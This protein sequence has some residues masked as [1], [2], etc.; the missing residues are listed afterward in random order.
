MALEP[1]PGPGSEGEYVKAGVGYHIS[2]NPEDSGESFSAGKGAARNSIEFMKRRYKLTKVDP[3]SLTLTMVFSSTRYELEQMLEGVRAVTGSSPLV[4]CTTAG[5]ITDEG[6]H[7]DSVSVFVLSSELIAAGTGVGE[8]IKEDKDAEEAGMKAASDALE[9]LKDRINTRE[10]AILR[11]AQFLDPDV[12]IKFI[13]YSV[14]MFPPGMSTV[15]GE[16]FITRDDSIIAGLLEKIDYWTPIIGGSSG[17]G[18]KVE[19]SYQFCNDGVYEKSVVCAILVNLVK[20][21]FSTELP[22][23][24]TEKTTVVTKLSDSYPPFYSPFGRKR[25]FKIKELG[26]IPAAEKYFELLQN[27]IKETDIREWLNRIGDVLIPV[28]YDE[29]GNPIPEREFPLGLSDINGKMWARVPTY[30]RK[31]DNSIEF[32]SP[33]PKSGNLT[34]MEIP[35]K[36]TLGS[37][38]RADLENNMASE[39]LKKAFR[40]NKVPLSSKVRISKLD[41]NRW[42]IMDREKEYIIRESG[43][44]LYIHDIKTLLCETTKKAVE[45]AISNAKIS[46]K[47]DIAAVIL[48]ICCIQRCMTSGVGW[49]QFN[50]IKEVVGEDT[51]I[52]GFYTYGEQL[53]ALFAA[54]SRVEQSATVMIISKRASIGGVL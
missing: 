45:R 40:D 29:V 52:I 39:D 22:F 25:G 30:I 54:P 4:G 24:P 20:T 33:I 19:R 38:F 9:E 51:P 49:S 16:F 12:M 7:N 18:M 53:S 27:R 41:K 46:S 31:E 32:S 15:A 26:G 34:L 36:F 43:N 35:Q 48:F 21:G 8:G 3:E 2:P 23:V 11:I 5:E 17:D 1:V 13:P 50:T 37:Q 10:L 47:E 6:V 42:E 14:I 28:G 44:Q